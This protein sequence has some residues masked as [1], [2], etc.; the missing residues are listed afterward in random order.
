[1]NMTDPQWRDEM[2][3]SWEYPKKGFVIDHL[4]RNAFFHYAERTGNAL[5]PALK[6]STSGL[7]CDSWEVETKY[8]TTPGFEK[9]FRQHTAI[10]M[11]DY[12]KDLYSNREPYRSV[13]YDYMKL[14]SRVRDRRVLQAFYP[15]ESRAGSLLPSAVRRRAVRHHLGLCRG[16]CAGDRGPLVRAHVCQHRRVGRRVGRKASRDVARHLLVSTAFPPI[17]SATSRRPI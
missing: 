14:V 2:T 13:R 4:N 3:G 15:E 12:I 8:M 6:G 7:F 10:R 9:R 1:M 17:T 16:R 11:K 5:R